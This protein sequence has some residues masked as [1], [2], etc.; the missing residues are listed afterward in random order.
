MNTSKLDDMID[1]ENR[2][3]EEEYQWYRANY[4]E[5]FENCD[6]GGDF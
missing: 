3:I 6:D 5:F 4:P 2:R 1:E